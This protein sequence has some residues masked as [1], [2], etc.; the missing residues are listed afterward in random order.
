MAK[1]KPIDEIRIGNLKAAIWENETKS[2]GTMINVTF[3]RLY[4]TDEGWKSSG[5]YGRDDLL[6]LAKLADRAHTAIIERQQK[7]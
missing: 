7:E 5:S 6:V 2:S 4:K 3:E 1:N